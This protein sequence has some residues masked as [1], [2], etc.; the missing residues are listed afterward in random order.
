[1]TQQQWM[2][3]AEALK[4]A[5]DRNS[6]GDLAGAE[7]L[8]RQVL[9]TQPR[10]AAALHLLGVVLHRKGDRQ[11]AIDALK[12]AV[13]ADAGVAL[14]HTNLG[15]MLRQ[16]GRVDEAVSEAGCAVALEPRNV[17]ALNNLGVALYDREEHEQAAAC[18]RRA[19]ELEPGSPQAYSNL[20][21]AL[22]ALGKPGEALPFYR[23]AIALEP[24]YV[25]AHNNLAM[26]LLLS[27]EF[28][29]GWR[30]LEWRRRRSGRSQT[31]PA[32]PEW[33]GESFAGKTLLVMGEEGHGDSIH[34]MRYLPAMAARGGSLVVAVHR[35]LVGLTRMLLPGAEVVALEAPR[36]RFDLWCSMM[37]LPRLFGTT[38]ESVPAA[39]PYLSV[40]PATAERWRDRLA[41]GGMKVGVV[42]SGE[43]RY[44]H[45][46]R[47]AIPAQRLVPLLGMAGVRWFSLQVGAPAAELAG[48]PAGVTDLSPMLT[49]FSETAGALLALDLVISTDTSV[50]HLAGALARPTWVMLAF[51]PD[52]RWML[53]RDTSPWYP[54]MRLFRQPAPG[55][56]DDVVRRIG[57]ELRAVL[58]GRRDRLTPSRPGIG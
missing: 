5:H 26:T 33:Q 15:E 20:G 35:P 6:A 28:E 10:H 29:E 40:D 7:D 19:I 53:D 52:W 34:F 30:E 48:L 47:R 13:A 2:P 14:Y 8:S 17:A 27:G 46:Y 31:Q 3:V 43:R 42:W 9:K 22:Q 21:N 16:A 24:D 56:W 18:Y 57:V 55:A 1:M 51:V 39:V 37:S 49:D 45:N 50:P 11:G 36:P 4:L 38:L 32:A 25:D 23:R 54:T 41:G 44:L 12:Q 58:A